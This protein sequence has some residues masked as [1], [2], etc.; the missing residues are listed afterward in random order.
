MTWSASTRVDGIAV[1]ALALCIMLVIAGDEAP[2][3]DEKGDGQVG[4][5]FF[6]AKGCPSCEHVRDLLSAL[7]D[8]YP[9][10]LRTFDTG[11]AEDNALLDRLEQIHARDKFSVPLVMLDDSILM[12]EREIDDKLEPM[13][14]RLVAA[15]GSALPYLGPRRPLKRAPQKHVD[16]GCNCKS[17]RPP[18][19]GEEWGK[20]KVLLRRFF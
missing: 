1:L 18:T 15:G 13:V 7:G 4:I 3:A 5:V 11:K 19:L 14:R 16:S 17:G 2:G 8:Q 9:L 10:D 12:G 6:G 20:L